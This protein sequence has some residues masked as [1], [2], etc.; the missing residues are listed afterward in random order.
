ME[1]FGAFADGIAGAIFWPFVIL[2]IIA[3][4]TGIAGAIKH[5]DTPYASGERATANTLFV[6]AVHSLIFMWGLWAIAEGF[7]EPN[8]M[9]KEKE[10][11]KEVTVASEFQEVFGKCMY[12]GTRYIQ[13]DDDQENAILERCTTTANE[14]VH[15]QLAPKEQ[16][17]RTLFNTCMGADVTGGGSWSVDG[18]RPGEGAPL[19]QERIKLCH[20]QVKEIIQ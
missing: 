15:G 9:M 11:I 19:R 1:W 7:P 8:Y 4:I 18:E 12:E 13:T 17:Y 3:V 2:S 20:A 5:F 6:G 14:Q 16:R 10:V